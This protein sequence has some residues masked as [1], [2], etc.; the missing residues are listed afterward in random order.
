MQN[1]PTIC[2]NTWYKA[3]IVRPSLIKRSNPAAPLTKFAIPIAKTNAYIPLTL[4]LH[5]LR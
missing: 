5:C 3:N 2:I 4:P 1:M